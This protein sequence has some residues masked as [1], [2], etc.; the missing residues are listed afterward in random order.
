MV[1]D[2]EGT[3]MTQRNV[4]KLAVISC[5]LPTNDDDGLTLT[6]P[7]MPSL[8]V[9]TFTNHSTAIEVTVW[10]D[11]IQADD[12]GDDAAAWL[13]KVLGKTCRLVRMQ[14]GFVRQTDARYAPISETGLSDGFPILLASE[15]SIAELNAQLVARGKE[16]ISMDRFR[17]NIVVKR[18]SAAC[19]PFPEDLWG[20]I[21]IGEGTKMR[22]CKP[23]S[24][25]SVPGVDQVI[26]VA[27]A[28]YCSIGNMIAGTQATGKMDLKEPA[29]T[30]RT[31]RSGK[32]LGLPYQWNKSSW[33][34]EVFFGQ[35]IISV[36]G[37]TTHSIKVGDVVQVDSLITA[38]KM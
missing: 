35:N 1:V 10:D 14:P 21:T 28:V 20:D 27:L 26:I 31:F 19:T 9:P 23:C 17:P 7:G 33:A 37:G 8:V 24:R 22:S 36:A 38:R 18:T 30:M 34:D 25:C 32:A 6:A 11:K 5:T 3:M 2:T 29:A 15:E 12:Q 13:V 4:P 16:E